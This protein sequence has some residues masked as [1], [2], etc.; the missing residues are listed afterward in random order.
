MPK[1]LKCRVYNF[2]PR[3]KIKGKFLMIELVKITGKE[4][5]K[6]LMEGERNFTRIALVGEPLVPEEIV[7]LNRYLKSVDLSREPVILDL[8]NLS[9][10]TIPGI[11]AL[12]TRARGIKAIGAQLPGATLTYADLTPYVHPN[13]TQTR[14]DLSRARFTHTQMSYSKISGARVIRTGF[15]F[16]NLWDAGMEDM[17]GL[18]RALYL[19]TAIMRPQQRERIND[20]LRSRSQPR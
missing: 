14:S 16:T 11:Y 8:S 10:A 19:D 1:F 12:H 9:G 18:E 13:N 4:L 17:I 7:E 5:I 3:V 15:M 20:Y 2:Y 6:R